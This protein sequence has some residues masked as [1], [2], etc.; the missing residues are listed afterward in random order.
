MNSPRRNS[1]G[2]TLIE[3]IVALVVSSMLAVVVVSGLHLAIRSWEAVSDNIHQGND[4]YVSMHALRRV[5]SSLRPEKVRDENGIA[6]AAF[7]GREDQ[8]L[9]IAPMEQLGSLDDLYWVMISTREAES[10]DRSLILNLLPFN[11]KTNFDDEDN[12]A[13]QNIAWEE[14]IDEILELESEIIV[15]NQEFTGI[16]FDYMRIDNNGDPVWE[17]EWLDDAQLPRSIRVQL[18]FG[19]DDEWP[20]LYILPKT[21]TYEFKK[22][23]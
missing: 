4:T 19:P 23:L 14:K 20:N 10:G 3:M 21:S 7:Y 8:V 2:F 5:L 9:F 22:L 13:F 18:E 15:G 1:G 12:A 16:T 6:V 17:E 11:Q